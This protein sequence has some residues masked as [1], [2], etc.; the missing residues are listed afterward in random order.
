MTSDLMDTKL[1]FFSLLLFYSFFFSQ[2]VKKCEKKKNSW[3][4]NI[5]FDDETKWYD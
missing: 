4:K 3:E 1:F 2:F 5:T